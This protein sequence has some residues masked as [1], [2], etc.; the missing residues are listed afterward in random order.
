[1]RLDGCAVAADEVVLVEPLASWRGTD[2]ARSAD[3]SAAVFGVTN[4]AVRRL[5][6]RDDPAATALADAVKTAADKL[7][8]AAYALIDDVEPGQQVD[9]RLRLRAQAHALACRATQGL[10]AVGAG[11]SMLLDSAAQRLARVAL[12]LLVQGQTVAVREATLRVLAE[13]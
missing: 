1:V 2:A 13:F 7:R 9:E 8:S 3:V 12:F 6:E 10:V 5:R 4:E 11:R